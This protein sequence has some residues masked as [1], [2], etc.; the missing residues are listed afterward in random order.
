[1]RRVSDSPRSV[2]QVI[3]VCLVYLMLAFWKSAV[4]PL[5]IRLM[6]QRNVMMPI[7]MYQGRC[8]SIENPCI[9]SFDQSILSRYQRP[10]HPQGSHVRLTS[11]T[12]S[13]SCPLRD[14]L[15]TR[16]RFSTCVAR[17]AVP[18]GQKPLHA[19]LDEPRIVD[20]GISQSAWI[21]KRSDQD[22]LCG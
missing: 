1:M 16:C 3:G 4:T 20:I 12:P 6:A 14:L 2:L 17:R 19:S 11:R 7:K 15:A 21:I 10:I 5:L 8:S 9:K 18:D 22:R 13:L